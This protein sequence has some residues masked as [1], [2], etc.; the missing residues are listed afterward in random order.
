MAEQSI[1]WW[2][3]ELNARLARTALRR[4]WLRRLA[5]RTIGSLALVA[6]GL[7]I[8]LLLTQNTQGQLM[9]RGTR[10]RRTGL[11]AEAQATPTRMASASR[12]RS[13]SAGGATITLDPPATTKG[14]GTTL[15]VTVT[16]RAGAPLPGITIWLTI[17]GVAPFNGAA[18]TDQSGVADFSYRGNGKPYTV[19]IT[20]TVDGST[21]AESTV[22]VGSSPSISTSEV[23]ARFYA[24]DGRCTYD[25]PAGTPPLFV[26]HFPAINFEGRP[27]TDYGVKAGQPNLV[28]AHGADR[29]GMGRLNHFN[30][31]FTGSLVVHRAGDVPFTFLIDDA[32]NFGVGNG[33][34]RISG[35]MSSPPP[36]G[37]TA[38][39]R[40]PVMGAFNQGHLEA[41]T[42][43]TVRFPRPG[44][45]PFEI[46]YAECMAGDAAI[47]ISTA[48]QFLQ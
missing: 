24:S 7:L 22:Q 10:Q 46:D 12:T 27:F 45:Y 41:L 36:S 30:A 34:T 26:Q 11:L 42:N 32:F 15:R 2:Q 28:A 6:L 21:V 3:R 5:I 38:L 13:L 37:L 16:D 40:L 31:A 39:E 44:T 14:K 4:A 18:T 35:T 8:V 17:Q 19:H 47:R 43:T 20:A 33:A 1:P 23:T 48:G 9:A 29:I 25:T